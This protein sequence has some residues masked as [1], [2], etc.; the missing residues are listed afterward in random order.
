MNPLIVAASVIVTGL[1][2][3]LA[4]IGP[5]VGHGTAAGQAIDGEIARSRRENM[6]YFIA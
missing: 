2:V 5:R 1:A 3:G 6:S 4:S